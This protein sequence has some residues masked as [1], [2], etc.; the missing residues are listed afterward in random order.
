M[1]IDSNSRQIAFF[2]F[3]ALARVS[4]GQDN[5]TSGSQKLAESLFDDGKYQAAIEEYE[6]VAS[7]FHSA[8]QLDDYCMSKIKI[9]E[10]NIR[11]GDAVVG[12]ELA[13]N[14]L[15]FI[16]SNEIENASLLAETYNVI[17]D[18][19]LNLGRNDR[20]LEYLQKSLEEFQGIGNA[21]SA[22][23]AN[24]YNDLG[25]VYWNNGNNHLALQYHQNALNIRKKL[26]ESFKVYEADSYNNIGLVYSTYDYKN[27]ASNFQEAL[28]IY[29]GEL[30][31][32]NP[33]VAL[34]YNNLALVSRSQK[35]YD[36]A[37][38]YLDEVLK[39]WEEVFE[40]EHPNMA[41]TYLSMGIVHA[42]D[43]NYAQAVVSLENALKTYHILYGDK[44]PEIA[45]VY[46]NLGGVYL[47]KGDF[48]ESIDYYQKAIY[49]NLYDQDLTD[50]YTN[51]ELSGYYNADLLLVSLQE[52]AKAFET[53][54]YNKTLKIRDLKVSLEC[55][56][57]ADKLVSRIRKIRLGEKDKLSL[58]AKASEIYDAGV[59]LCYRMSE[60]VMKP[61]VYLEKAFDFA[62]KSKSSTLLSAIQDTNAKQYAGIPSE[63]LTKEG[64][65]KNDIAYLERKLAENSG[66]DQEKIFKSRLLQTNNEYNAFI[67]NLEKEYPRYYNLKFNEQYI[68]L[69]DLQKAL[70]DQTAFITHFVTAER[71]YCFYITNSKLKVFDQPKMEKYDNYISGMRNSIKYDSKQHFVTAASGLY[72][73]LMPPKI[74]SVIQRLIIIP[75]GK[76]ATIPF[77]ALISEIPKEEEFEYQQLPFLVKRFNISYDNSATLFAQRK[78]EIENYEGETE[79]ILLVAPVNFSDE[80]YANMSTRLN[81]LPGSKTEIDEIKILFSAREHKTHLLTE[82]NATEIN[83]KSEE[84][85]RYKYLH[86]ATHG[87]VN[88]S[89]PELS[90]IFLRPT[91]NASED[92]SLYSG[93]I[94]NIDINADLVCLSACQTGLGKLSKG[95]GLIG[96]SR[97]LLYAGA[98]NLVVSLWTVSDASTSELM[99]DFYR[100]HLFSSSYNTFSGALRKSK[101]KLIND[102]RFSK[103]YYWAPFILIGE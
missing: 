29:Q 8:K 19:Y 46:N 15:N 82:D 61:S 90:R 78:T 94:Y 93:E 95:E 22:D 9:A 42:N 85:H 45:N 86:F 71:V 13:E 103:P 36:Q 68:S 30:G 10:S 34:A 48:E 91:Y 3:L 77:E 102:E 69:A 99:I 72:G 92:G 73:Q 31:K 33:K 18:A 32:N 23:L 65:L 58:S 16:E 25:V 66:S 62:E 4:F 80:Y 81:D 12:L 64:S 35:R 98:E 40:G 14:T 76:L 41:F 50:R 79:D 54:H 17:G 5:S 37:L 11:L 47:A 57:L 56:E 75:E 59:E 26:G 55:L 28:K 52:K 20:A 74:P 83:L 63:L 43:D 38:S 84:L 6:R 96:L 51:P 39:I 53:Y 67:L 24:C 89:K 27:A 97:A 70:D 88:E 2:L 49:A 60:V 1:F 100:N 87:I 44:H 7:S 21:Q 101:L